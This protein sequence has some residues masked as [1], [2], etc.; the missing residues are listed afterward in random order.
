MSKVGYNNRRGTRRLYRIPSFFRRSKRIRRKKGKPRGAEKKR[1]PHNEK[2]ADMVAGIYY[3]AIL[4]FNGTYDGRSSSE[5]FPRGGK[6][7]CFRFYSVF[8]GDSHRPDKR[9]LL[10]QRLSQSYKGFA[11]YG[12]SYRLGI[13]SG[14]SVRN[15]RHIPHRLRIGTRR[16][17]SCG[18]LYDESLF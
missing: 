18:K 10:Y 5:L 6:L 11:E 15:N 4:H 2:T 16:Y 8:A 12:Y 17:R 14:A 1:I 13:R 9:S 3:T 7:A